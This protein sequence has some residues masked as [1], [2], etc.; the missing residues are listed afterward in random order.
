MAKL[1][2]NAW[3]NPVVAL[4]VQRHARSRGLAGWA[5]LTAALAGG[6]ALGFAARPALVMPVLRALLLGRFSS[7]SPGEAFLIPLVLSAF[8]F[9]SLGVTIPQ[10]TLAI[11]RDREQQAH[12]HAIERAAL[13]RRLVE[14][15][16]QSLR[17]QL[18]PHFLFNA[19]NTVS[20]FTETDPRM[21]VGSSAS[22]AR[23]CA[24]RS[25]T[26]IAPWSRS[27]RN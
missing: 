13:E 24:C 3:S 5:V 9:L 19:L 4:A 16:L 21:G 18:Q 25:R 7:P 14:A 1:P 26:P 10:A 27:V 2:P 6:V 12:A 22:S 15:H 20:A 8:L 23:S 11:V 17:V